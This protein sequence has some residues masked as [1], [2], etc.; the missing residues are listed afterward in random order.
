M[1][2]QH[3]HSQKTKDEQ[4]NY[5]TGCLRVTRWPFVSLDGSHSQMTNK[6]LSPGNTEREASIVKYIPWDSLEGLGHGHQGLLS[7]SSRSYI[8]ASRFS[9]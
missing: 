2:F 6:A 4:A 7:H 3:R 8:S 5:V 1:V 9:Y